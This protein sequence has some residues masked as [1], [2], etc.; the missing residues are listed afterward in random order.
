M[1]FFF[2][3]CVC[4]LALARCAERCVLWQALPEP[5]LDAESR[6]AFDT[7]YN[8]IRAFHE[9][10]RAADVE[11]ETMPGVRCRRI[12][13]PIGALALRRVWCTLS[14]CSLAAQPAVPGETGWDKAEPSQIKVH[15]TH[16]AQVFWP[17][18]QKCTQNAC[19]YSNSGGFLVRRAGAVGL[20]VPG[21]TAVLP[22]TT[23]MLAVPAAL[24]GCQTV[25]MATPPRPDGTV[26]PEVAYCARKAGVTHVLKA[27][28]AQAVAALAWGTATC[29]KV[30]LTSAAYRNLPRHG[31]TLGGPSEAC[32][33][34]CVCP[35]PAACTPGVAL[36]WG[37]CHLLQGDL[38]V[39]GM[40][41]CSCFLST[42]LSIACLRLQPVHA[43]LSMP[44]LSG[45][46]QAWL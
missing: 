28:G 33:A 39:R 25:V 27:G 8:N 9:A 24:A 29:P 41:G 20:Y 13:R 17:P 30:C 37:H 34:L 2:G 44:R 11:V 3:A 16:G 6:A 36:A 38:C 22:S 10:Q 45:V 7:A 32:G 4:Q 1:D 40:Q 21:G 42:S 46:R 26:T 18:S 19:L 15:L 12:T 23:L 43:P 14:T 31:I 5:E 35:R